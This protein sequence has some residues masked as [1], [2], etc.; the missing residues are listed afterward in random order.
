MSK[1]SGCGLFFYIEYESPSNCTIY[2]YIYILPIGV[3]V[4]VFAN[5]LRSRGLSQSKDSKIGTYILNYKVWIKGKWSNI[6]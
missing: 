1:D 3:M 5:G 4:R 2:I 6:K